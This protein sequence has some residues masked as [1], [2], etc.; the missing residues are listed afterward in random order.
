MTQ[1]QTPRRLTNEELPPGTVDPTAYD[2]GLR[3][4]LWWDHVSK[5]Y[6]CPYCSF[7]TDQSDDV[8][9]ERHVINTHPRQLAYPRT[10]DLMTYKQVLDLQEGQTR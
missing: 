5:R 2:T 3:K 10:I 8:T 1:Q 6:T 9:Y 4:P 7:K